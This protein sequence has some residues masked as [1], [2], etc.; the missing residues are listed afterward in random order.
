MV[1]RIFYTPYL[2]IFSSH[3][4]QI[5]LLLYTTYYMQLS[6]P[7]FYSLH[8]VIP[9]HTVLQLPICLSATR[10]PFLYTLYLGYFPYLLHT[11]ASHFPIQSRTLSS[12]SPAC[13]TLITVLILWFLRSLIR[14][15][16]TCF[17]IMKN[18][19]EKKIDCQ[20]CN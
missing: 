13:Y 3:R 20:I 12:H 4:M 19:W 6:S 1:I 8:L 10:Q 16:I 5:A 11:V 17:L 9:L 18:Q 2:H 14:Q 15:T 7:F